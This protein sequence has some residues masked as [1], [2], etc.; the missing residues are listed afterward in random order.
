MG[1]LITFGVLCLIWIVGLA[2]LL[3]KHGE[4]RILGGW[5]VGILSIGIPAFYGIM[6]FTQ[7]QEGTIQVPKL[8][9]SVFETHYDAGAEFISPWLTTVE[10]DVRSDTL[11]FSG[12]NTL[13]T[14]SGD[15]VYIERFDL[16]VSYRV[17][18]QNAWAIVRHIGETAYEQ[19]LWNASRSAARTVLGRWNWQ[20]AAT[21]RQ[22]EFATEIKSELETLVSDRLVQQGVPTELASALFLFSTPEIRKILPPVTIR[23]AG[24]ALQAADIEE[25]RQ[26]ALT[27]AEAEIAKRQTEV[28]GGV[29]NL[30]TEMGMTPSNMTAAEVALVLN[31][32]AERQRAETFE[33]LVRKE[34]SGID[35]GVVMGGSAAQPNIAMPTPGGEAHTFTPTE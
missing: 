12:Q 31:A 8:F 2:I 29:F 20:E 17:N 34:D 27:R 30:L 7:V 10:F 4:D 25:D 6:S 35:W 16:N 32:L 22:D 5:I 11:E 33:Q 1:F 19:V 3:L 26:I 23:E 21:T 15:G 14:F 24:A 9:G 28:G 13:D 18:E